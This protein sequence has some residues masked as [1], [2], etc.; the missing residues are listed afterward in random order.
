MC[1]FVCMS[2]LVDMFVNCALE[3]L[4]WTERNTNTIYYYYII[5]ALVE[6]AFLVHSYR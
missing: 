6:Q 2:A 1:F 5:Y 4:M 3:H